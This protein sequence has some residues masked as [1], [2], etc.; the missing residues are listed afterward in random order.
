MK[1]RPFVKIMKTCVAKIILLVGGGGR[2]SAFFQNHTENY[3]QVGVEFVLLIV[4]QLHISVLEF[5]AT[6]ALFAID[7]MH[8]R[9]LKATEKL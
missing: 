3:F 8:C 5:I 7:V 9:I 2:S 4:F 1:T 6:A